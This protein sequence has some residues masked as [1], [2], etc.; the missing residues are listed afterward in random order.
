MHIN[1]AK[2]RPK[3][4]IY[5]VFCLHFW[6]LIEK[7]TKRKKPP[8][9]LLER[10]FMGRQIFWINTENACKRSRLLILMYFTCNI[11]RDK[12][13]PIGEEVLS[14]KRPYL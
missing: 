6:F 10:I 3:Y 7:I 2:K 1:L 11:Y 14:H 5:P 12:R 13:S 8:V 9:S 4:L